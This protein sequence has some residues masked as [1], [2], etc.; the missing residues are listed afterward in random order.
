MLISN[1]LSFNITRVKGELN[2]ITDRLVVF[3]TSPTRQILP[4]RPDCT[5]Q[6]LYRPHIPDNIES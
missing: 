4:Q 3:A 5:F 1:M 2:S 6:S